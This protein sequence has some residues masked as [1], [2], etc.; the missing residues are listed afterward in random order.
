[1]Y[2]DLLITTKNSFVGI[3]SVSVFFL[4]NKSLLRVFVDITVDELHF[5][6]EIFF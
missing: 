2:G 1:M 6:Y 4:S 5:C 3:P